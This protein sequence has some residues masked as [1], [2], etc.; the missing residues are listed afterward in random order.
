MISLYRMLLENVA[1]TRF[2]AMAIGIPDKVLR[3][4][5]AVLNLNFVTLNST[6]SLKQIRLQKFDYE[7]RAHIPSKLL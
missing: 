4:Q 6:T 5:G 3:K 2:Q 1:G 7:S